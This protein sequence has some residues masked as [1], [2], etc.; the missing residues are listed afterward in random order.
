M[1]SGLTCD[2]AIAAVDGER[3]QA[4]PDLFREHRGKLLRMI[5]LRLDS[6]LMGKVDSDDVLQEVFVEA[7]R[8]FPQYMRQP[9]AP[10]FVWLRQL[11]NQALI[12]LHRRFLG[13]RM[14]NVRQEVDLHWA[15]FS[16]TSA[17][18]LAGQLADSLTTPSQCAVRG[19]SLLA[20]KAALASIDP[21]DREVLMLRHLEE[22]SN[23]EVAQVLG[24][25]KSAASKRYLRA[26]VRLRSMM[27]A[28]T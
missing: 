18:A 24:L 4:L 22:L 21:I 5:L 2:E 25:D 3:Q 12:D 15:E 26:L 9:T 7:V 11:T 17:G 1:A 19:E 28:E 8:R 6:R 27:P 14:R 20:M 16:D 23:N 10:V 13:A